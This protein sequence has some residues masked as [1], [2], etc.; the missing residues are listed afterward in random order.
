MTRTNI[1]IYAPNASYQQTSVT[2]I[3]ERHSLDKQWEHDVHYKYA[4][5]VKL[6]WINTKKL[7]IINVKSQTHQKHR[8]KFKKVEE[9]HI[10][11]GTNFVHV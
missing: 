3:M 8:L 11:M 4:N 7:L 9:L 1:F 10:N 6:F 2:F 5:S